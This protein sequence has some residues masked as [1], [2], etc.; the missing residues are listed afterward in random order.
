MT[1]PAETPEARR[2]FVAATRKA[3]VAVT[4]GYNPAGQVITEAYQVMPPGPRP[5]MPVAEVVRAL[6]ETADVLEAAGPEAVL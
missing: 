3:T 2:H 4:V 6:R 5:L 1:A